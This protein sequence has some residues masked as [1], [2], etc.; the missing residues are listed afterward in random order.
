MK[1]EKQTPVSED[2]QAYFPWET[3]EELIDLSSV[4]AAGECT[5]LVPA[6]P[7]GDAEAEAYTDLYPIPKPQ[8]DH[9]SGMHDH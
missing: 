5:G 1:K 7:E 6:P 4:A 2:K 8:T 9:G 3:E